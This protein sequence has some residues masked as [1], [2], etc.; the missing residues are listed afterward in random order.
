MSDPASP[1]KRDTSVAVALQ[2]DQEGAP[3]VTAVGRGLIGAKIV[4]TAI[5]AGVPLQED[6][7]LAEALSHVELDTEI[8]EHLYQAVAVVISFILK[9]RKT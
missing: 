4:E 7:V 3:R 6:P 2:Y 8:P 1:E 9:L 5:A